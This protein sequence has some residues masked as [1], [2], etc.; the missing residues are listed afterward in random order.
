M[1]W[2]ECKTQ[3]KANIDNYIEKKTYQKFESALMALGD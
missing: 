3:T 1:S 2:D